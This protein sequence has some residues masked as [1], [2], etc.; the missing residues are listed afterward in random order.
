LTRGPPQSEAYALV[1]REA[2]TS[3]DR[4]PGG[5]YFGTSTGTFGY[6]HDSGESWHVMAQYL[7]P[8]YSVSA[9]VS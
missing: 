2:M 5:I 7:P 1:L 6:S 9:T 3:N 8:V 4:G